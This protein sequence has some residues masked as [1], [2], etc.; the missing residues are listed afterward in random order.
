[1]AVVF[2]CSGCESRAYKFPRVLPKVAHERPPFERSVLRNGQEPNRS[3][4]KESVRIFLANL[5]DFRNCGTVIVSEGDLGQSGP[6][7]HCRDPLCS[8]IH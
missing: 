1:M 5:V 7:G 6:L 4:K 2:K 8:R 3:L